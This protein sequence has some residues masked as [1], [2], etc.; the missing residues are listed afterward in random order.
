MGNR[1]AGEGSYGEK[2]IKGTK[3]FYFRDVNGKYT[4][5]RTKK[6]LK[7]KLQKKQQEQVT[8]LTG[9]NSDATL[10]DYCVQWMKYKKLKRLTPIAK[11]DYERIIDNR[12][13]NTFIG[14]TQ[15]GEIT[16]SMLNDYLE[17]LASK[18]ARSTLLKTWSIMKQ[19]IA[20]GMGEGD[21]Q[22]INLSKIYIPREAEVAVK[23]KIIQYIS[24]SD[25]DILWEESK[26]LKYGDGAKVLAF[27]MYTGL[28]VSEA[29]AL[30][31]SNVEKD[32]SAINVVESHSVALKR[33]NKDERISKDGKNEYELIVKTPKTESGFRTIPCSSRAIEILQYMW[34]KRKSDD[35]Y[36]FL[37]RSGK[38]YGK[39]ALASTLGHMMNSSNCSRKD[40]TIHGLR[41]GFGSVLISKGVD[42]KIVSKLLGHK[43]ISTTYDI[44][45]GVY[46]E[47]EVAAIKNV[48]DN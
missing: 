22:Q 21:F 35:G 1:K 20:F 6:E 34:N 48:F 46:K 47:D 23:K 18:Y 24:M 14:K 9:D 30:R 15:V 16:E 7:E 17:D 12:I 40:Y 11:D 29:T 45:I 25:M 44:Y 41:H 28:R 36:V 26:K 43:N 13:Q 4:Y 19:V 33:N 39:R 27:I 32:F 8:N 2:N 42:I 38:T 5:G 37:T 31:W 10:Y 3:Y